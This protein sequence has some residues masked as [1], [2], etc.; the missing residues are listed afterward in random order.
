LS[1]HGFARP[2]HEE[3]VEKR[4]V[5]LVKQKIAVEFEISGQKRPADQSQHIPRL[6]GIPER[7]RFRG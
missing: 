5:A 1:Q 4:R 7:R 3:R 2:A 6:P